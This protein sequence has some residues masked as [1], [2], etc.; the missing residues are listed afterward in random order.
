MKRPGFIRSAATA[1]RHRRD[2]NHARQRRERFRSCNEILG[3]DHP[4]VAAIEAVHTVLHQSLA[5]GAVLVVSLTAVGEGDS[6]ASAFAG[7]AAIVLLGLGIYAALL[8]QDK[9]DR[10]LDLIVE[11]REGVP[12][13][14]VQR[15]RRRLLAPRTRRT[16]AGSLH[17]VILDASKDGRTSRFV[18]RVPVD[19]LVVAAVAPELRE[20]IVLLG[21]DQIAARGV[22]AIERLLTDGGSALYRH[23]AEP[24]RDELH[25][26]R[27]L[28]E[29]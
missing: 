13:R 19:V 14:A 27:Y 11:G 15:Q 22:A 10:V 25:R 18:A 9:R 2:E 24:L 5:V 26:I 23:E 8:Q 21:A 3:P 7:S 16:L 6:W 12:V 28:L 4:L 29:P 20:V 1:G 17:A